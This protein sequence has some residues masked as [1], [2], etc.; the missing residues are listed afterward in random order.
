MDMSQENTR[1]PIN[2]L[3]DLYTFSY[4][5]EGQ[6]LESPETA[7]KN[8][9]QAGINI[10]ST[11]QFIQQKYNLER[12]RKKLAEGKEARKKFLQNPVLVAAAETIDQ[13]KNQ[14]ENFLGD[15]KERKPR[16]AAVYFS[17]FKESSD[18]D[19]YSLLEDLRE[20]E[21]VLEPL[22]EKQK[23]QSD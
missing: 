11:L 3:N 2:I 19:L 23:D 17:R 6:S 18:E 4:G 14:I 5:D 1:E 10:D 22:D 13:V 8:L 12:N 16:V 20:L 21:A 7:K 15:L 9:E